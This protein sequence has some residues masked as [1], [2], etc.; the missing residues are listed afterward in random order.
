MC[1]RGADRG[2]MLFGIRAVATSSTASYCNLHDSDESR[3]ATKQPFACPSQHVNWARGEWRRFELACGRTW[4]SAV[5]G[6]GMPLRLSI[7]DARQDS[8]FALWPVLSFLQSGGGHIFNL[9]EPRLRLE[10]ALAAY[11]MAAAADRPDLVVVNHESQK[12]AAIV[13]VKYL[14]GDT[15]NTRF[16][17]AA[18]QIVR[19]GRGYS[20][21]ADL[22]HL[23]RRSLI[24]LSREAPSLIDEAADAP[25]AVDFA[26]M[27]DGRLALGQSLLASDH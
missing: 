4:G 18:G 23:I 2:Q 7:L 8:Q 25:R 20:E 19:Y 5:C 10:V 26:G 3:L 1:H 27:L 11:G 6:A 22:P 9:P 24:A 21:E 14:A 12:V 15:A 17:E 13:E 16:R